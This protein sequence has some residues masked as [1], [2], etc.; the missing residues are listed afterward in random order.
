M[1]LISILL[2]T[3]TLLAVANSSEHQVIS[4]LNDIMQELDPLTRYQSSPKNIMF[5]VNMGASSHHSWVM[6]VL[7][8]LDRRGHK[9]TYATTASSAITREDRSMLTELLSIEE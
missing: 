8:E 6:R 1:I 9:I 5:G 3:A 4:N 2:V 7:D